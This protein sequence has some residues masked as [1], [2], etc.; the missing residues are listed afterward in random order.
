MNTQLVISQ[1]DLLFKDLFDNK[2]FN[3]NPVVYSRIGYPVDIIETE[4]GIRFEIAAVGLN[5]EDIEVLAE[6]ETL[7][8]SYHKKAETDKS[9]IYRSIT[10]K[11]FDL[12]WKISAKLNIDKLEASLDKGLLII[13]IPFSQ[14][15][16]TKTITIK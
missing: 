13:E 10:R 6:G 9:Y 5:K 2:N 8:V 4:Q 15:A 11:S 14:I 16:T 7:R 12:A 1:I 3:F